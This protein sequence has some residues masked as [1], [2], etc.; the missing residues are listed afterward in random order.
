MRGGPAVVGALSLALLVALLVPGEGPAI[1]A[2]L[3]TAT[4]P[5]ALLLLLAS[6]RRAGVVP[7]AGSAVAAVCV[8]GGFLVLLAAP[9]GDPLGRWLG[10]LPW[11]TG[12]LV[13]VIALLPLVVLGVIFGLG[14]P[15]WRPPAE[16]VE[17]LRRLADE[18]GEDG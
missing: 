5:A 12:V 14:W 3:L 10:G 2:T 6:R 4:M 13:W 9:D 18:A 1:L 8:G 15:R 11:A 7:L 17:R 16:A